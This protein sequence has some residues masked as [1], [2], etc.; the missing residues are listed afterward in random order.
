MLVSIRHAGLVVHL[1]TLGR[2]VKPG[3]HVLLVNDVLSTESYPVDELADEPDLIE[4]VEDL[5]SRI[6]V[7]EGGSPIVVKR[8][9]RRDTDLRALLESPQ[10]TGAWLWT[11]PRDRTYLVYAMR[12]QRPSQPPAPA[13]LAP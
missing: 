10:L 1:R 8:I 4:T 12:L 13:S 11:G 3:A 2:L 5:A 9:L 6:N 7:F